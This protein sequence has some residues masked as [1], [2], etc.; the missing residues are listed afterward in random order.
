M[1]TTI[2]ALP[3]AANFR[4]G[5]IQAEGWIAD[6]EYPNGGMSCNGSKISSLNPYK[7]EAERARWFAGFNSA[8]D[9]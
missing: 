3:Q 8:L 6:H 9:R 1:T 2:H 4:L 5:R 7:T